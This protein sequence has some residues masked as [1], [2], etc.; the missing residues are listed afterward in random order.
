MFGSVTNIYRTLAIPAFCHNYIQ[1]PN[2]LL[3]NISVLL[4]NSEVGCVFSQT[5]CTQCEKPSQFCNFWDGQDSKES[6]EANCICQYLSDMDLSARN[7]L[8][9]QA[10]W[11]KSTGLEGNRTCDG[12][13]ISEAFPCSS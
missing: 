2:G 3:L 7:G 12:F 10:H 1:A 13:I 11:W 6:L 4:S 8:Q 9:F 5:V